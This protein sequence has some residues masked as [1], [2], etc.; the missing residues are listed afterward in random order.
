M[1]R[2]WLIFP[3]SS[4]LAAM[5]PGAFLVWASYAGCEK[6]TVVILFTVGMGLMGTFYSGHKAN[7]LDLSPNYAGILMALSNGTGAIS[8]MIGPYIV[9]VI[10]TNVTKSFIY[11]Y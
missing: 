11:R 10:T 1:D 7:N 9:G 5:G 6:I 2:L 3:Y 8:G 4:K